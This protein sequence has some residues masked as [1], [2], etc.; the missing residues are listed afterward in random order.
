MRLPAVSPKRP[1]QPKRGAEHF[2]EAA[3]EQGKM[4]FVDPVHEEGVGN[5]EIDV[6]GAELARH[7]RLE[8]RVECLVAAE[9]R[10]DRIEDLLPESMG[11]LRLESQAGH[12]NESLL[13]GWQN[14]PQGWGWG[15]T[16][17]QRCQSSGGVTCVERNRGVIHMRD[18]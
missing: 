15:N 9:P 7:D 12:F 11:F 5:F 16:M 2:R 18:G 17:S 1:H 6:L 3:L 13:K 4:V 8:P 14:N 10:P